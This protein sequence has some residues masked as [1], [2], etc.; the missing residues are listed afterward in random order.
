MLPALKDMEL[1]ASPLTRF[2]EKCSMRS[3][4]ASEDWWAVWLGLLLVAIPLP[5]LAGTDVLGWVVKANVWLDPAKALSPT[6][7]GY[8]SVPGIVSLLGT[9]LFVLGLVCL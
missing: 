4:L 2:H 8:V 6:G 1:T 9:F 7:P 5:I 3:W